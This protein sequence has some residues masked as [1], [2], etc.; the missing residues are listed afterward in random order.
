MLYRMI[1]ESEGGKCNKL[2]KLKMM[3]MGVE[4]LFD[5]RWAASPY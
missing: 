5:I 1:H 4:V 3:G 2:E